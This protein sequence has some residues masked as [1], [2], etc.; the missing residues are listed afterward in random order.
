MII[1]KTPLEYVLERKR[2]WEVR[3]DAALAPGQGLTLRQKRD[4]VQRCE[5]AIAALQEILDPAYLEEIAD[6]EVCGWICP[7]CGCCKCNGC[8]VC[9]GCGESQCNCSCGD[10]LL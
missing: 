4:E 8:G 6:C 1:G 5:G 3:L 9:N 7:E 2:A 10:E